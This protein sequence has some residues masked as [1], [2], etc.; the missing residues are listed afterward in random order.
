MRLL[1]LDL[2]TSLLV[3]ITAAEQLPYVH[4]ISPAAGGCFE[5]GKEVPVS[6]QLVIPGGFASQAHEFTKYHALSEVCVS[7][8]SQGD[9]FCTRVLDGS[10]GEGHTTALSGFSE[11]CHTLVGWWRDEGH[12]NNSSA[13][14]KNSESLQNVS[15][16]EEHTS[17][18]GNRI[19]VGPAISVAVV[20]GSSPCTVFDGGDGGDGGSGG[21]GGGDEGVGGLQSGH[22][23]QFFRYRQQRRHRRE[24][25]REE[26]GKAH[27]TDAGRVDDTS[28]DN[29][30][31]EK[32]E[33]GETDGGLSREEFELLMTQVLQ[34]GNGHHGNFPPNLITGGCLLD[35]L[36]LLDDGGDD[37]DD[38]GAD[39]GS[40]GEG[41]RR[42]AAEA[43]ADLGQCQSRCRLG[44]CEGTSP[45]SLCS[46]ANPTSTATAKS[47]SD[48][49]TSPLPFD[50]PLPLC[51][52]CVVESFPSNTELLPR[53]TSEPMLARYVNLARETVL[54]TPYVFDFEASVSGD[55]FDSLQALTM[56]GRRR[57]DHLHALIQD[58]IW[59]SVPGDI[60]ECGCWRGGVSLF[61]AAAL[62]AYGETSDS[63]TNYGEAS[64]GEAWQAGKQQQRQQGQQGRQSQ[65]QQ[66]QQGRQQGQGQGRLVW[67][68]DSFEGLPPA[69]A[70]GLFPADTVHAGSDTDI[71]VLKANSV[72]VVR[73]A[74]AAMELSHAIRIIPGFFNDSLPAA[75]R[76]QFRH[77][78]LPPLKSRPPSLPGGGARGGVGAREGGGVGGERGGN[79]DGE[80]AA[81]GGFSGCF[82]ILR[83]DGDLYQSTL[84][85]L[86]F[87]YPLL[88][89]GGHVVVDDYTDWQ[90]TRDAVIDYRER[91]NVK[92]RIE[93]TWHDLR[94]DPQRGE[95]TR[96]VWWTKTK[97]PEGYPHDHSSSSSSHDG[98]SDGVVV[99]G[100][101][102]VVRLPVVRAQKWC[103]F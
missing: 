64:G 36:L 3:T 81:D 67:L 102:K 90:G 100:E 41:Q 72:E 75:V 95:L 77:P 103:G 70:E 87:L 97:E 38:D 59:R 78:S 37:E 26:G 16:D 82:S 43:A 32:G 23:C 98:D 99:Y 60:I 96:G 62:V 73:Q 63:E 74:A 31:E 27:A 58:V 15:N 5:V 20:V 101:G 66:Q 12:P 84:E 52:E 46:H 6:W 24:R 45:L 18:R 56:V 34:G 28:N 94:T 50:L 68:L 53:F 49:L 39:D 54:N 42:A 92:E 91:H 51:S 35:S 14:D 89:I 21:G 9:P 93:V 25:R 10:D 86:H 76:S 40:E 13:V 19:L 22:S 55:K 44:C 57:I 8:G 88:S 47:T 1:F 48:K 85:S 29:D 7:I 65:Q 80:D 11:G 2:I 83:L 61:A 30:K 4:F 17:G 69:N 71:M 33:E 79:G